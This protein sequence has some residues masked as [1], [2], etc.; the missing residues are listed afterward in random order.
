MSPLYPVYLLLR[1]QLVE[2]QLCN[3]CPCLQQNFWGISRS[4]KHHL[5]LVTPTPTALWLG[6][7][8]RKYVLSLYSTFWNPGQGCARPDFLDWDW[9]WDLMNSVSKVETETET[10]DNGINFWD[11]DWDF[12]FESQILRLRLRLCYFGL[13]VWDWDWDL[14]SLKFWDWDWDFWV[15]AKITFFVY[16][17]RSNIIRTIATWKSESFIKYGSTKFGPKSGIF[18]QRLRSKPW[19]YKSQKAKLRLICHISET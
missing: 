2:G 12:R 6:S 1:P 14:L 4:R 11:W 19:T 9:D 17:N 8:I 13:K 18:V 10:F 7:L 15:W 5:A 3:R 16:W